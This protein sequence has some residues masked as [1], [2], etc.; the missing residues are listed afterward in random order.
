MLTQSGSQGA[1]RR[2][3]R[4]RA[5]ARVLRHRK[6]GKRSRFPILRH[7]PY[8]AKS[9]LLAQLIAGC[10]TWSVILAAATSRCAS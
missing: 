9:R 5:G 10:E 1:P 6:R 4:A 7:A 8:E 3:S 2:A